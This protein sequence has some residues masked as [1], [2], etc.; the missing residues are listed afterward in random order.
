MAVD[1]ILCV[2]GQ[3]DIPVIQEQPEFTV[4]LLDSNVLLFGSPMSGK[5]NLI[6]LLITILH[7]QYRENEEQIFILDFGGALANFESLPL[8]AAYFDNANEEYVKR[9]FK[10]MEDQLKD[11]IKQLKG[12]NYRAATDN[13]PVHTTLFIDNV[14][15]FLDEPR[16]SAYQEKL[17][18]LCRDGLSK[19]ITIVMTASST[20]GLGSLM[21]NFK[22][23][24]ALE[25]PVDSY[26]EIFNHKVIPVGNNPGHGFANVTVIPEG[27]TG[28]FPLQVAYE[29]QLNIADD[30][31]APEFHNNLKVYFQNRTVKK[32]KRFPEVLTKLLYDSFV[33]ELNE[34]SDEHSVS[35][36]LDYTE[37]KPVT[38]DFNSSKAVAIYGKK[39]F[40]KTNT[41]NLLLENF[42]ASPQ[43][44]FVFL[45]DGREQ[46]KKIYQKVQSRSRYIQFNE[47][48]TID[49]KNSKGSW[50]ENMKL[51]PMQL[52]VKE[53]HENYMDLSQ[54]R[55]MSNLV[56]GELFGAG[57]NIPSRAGLIDSKY[58]IFVL[59]SKFLYV[60]S[61][62]SKIF[63]EIILPSLVARADEMNWI[64]IFTDVK[65]ISDSETRENFHSS[66]SAAYLLDSIAEF[67]GERGQKSLFG[68]MDVKSLKEEYAPCEEGDGYFYSIERDELKKLKFIRYEEE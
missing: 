28:T 27:I 6:R 26:M 1:K 67:V 51:S 2:L 48:M 58:T 35:V 64:F 4:D 31:S 54:V 41:L 52:L 33:A 22:Q 44:R 10:L 7:K 66:I 63:M 19:G 9:V 56:L 59:Q 14:N 46:L 11:N 68:S 5:T 18:K 53:I 57:V 49:F 17:A 36:G 47:E 38:I 50:T 42:I 3:Q 21:G 43:Y 61:I 65:A 40:G 62:A 20:K 30:I 8:V 25:M 13:Q 24:I 37:C 32:Y 16:Y 29:L 60:N 45:D 55:R 23:K 39:G 34:R 15:A 12:K